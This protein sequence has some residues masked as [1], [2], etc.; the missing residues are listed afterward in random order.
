MKMLAQL[1]SQLGPRT[2]RRPH[3]LGAAP[4]VV[5]P[6][7][8]WS[9]TVSNAVKFAAQGGP[10]PAELQ[11][12]RIAGG[13]ADGKGNAI[14]SGVYQGTVPY[15]MPTQFQDSA[16]TY[17]LVS[18]TTTPYPAPPCLPGE[19]LING[20]CVPPV[21]LLHQCPAGQTWDNAKQRGVAP[22]PPPVIT[23]HDCGPGM[24][25]DQASGKCLPIGGGTTRATTFT[26]VQGHKIQM[27]IS[28]ATSLPGDY[29]N[30][31]AAA[32]QAM[33]DASKGKN[34]YTVGNVM[35]NGS[36][37]AVTMVRN[38]PPVTVPS[39]ITEVVSGVTV[40]TTFTDQGLAASSGSSKVVYYVA[41]GAVV[42]GL[43]YLA[44]RKYGKKRR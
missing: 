24:L 19:T 12:G 29:L 22:A 32:F 35:Y 26:I 15:T 1:N 41:G 9:A 27:T 40:T 38:G 20:G 43:G 6:R 34:A 3:G 36:S 37:V 13:A 2:S 10:V 39:P 17:V 44:W 42:Y 18:S 28:S 16:S 31:D 23:L 30:K 11:A 25:W 7:H 4:T 21:I 8:G 14:V 5:L 33:L